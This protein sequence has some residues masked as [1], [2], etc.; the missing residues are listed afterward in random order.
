MKI[1]VYPG[2]FDPITNGHLDIIK[3]ALK[4]FDKV[5]I[6]VGEN[7]R[8]NPLFSTD[9][10]L[11]LIK[12]TTEALPVEADSFSG[13]LADYLKKKDCKTIIR[14]LRAVSDFDYEFQMAVVNRELHEDLETVFLM[15]GREYFYLNSSLVRELAKKQGNVSSLVPKEVE[16]ALQKKFSR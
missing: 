15:T 12:K 13:L 14:S 7:N 8:K 6:A 10:K 16:E 4:I 11:A 5:I 3:R 9:E 2:S 1:A